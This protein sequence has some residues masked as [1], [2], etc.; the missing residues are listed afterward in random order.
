MAARA[1]LIATFCVLTLAIC[2]TGTTAQAQTVDDLSVII[3]GTQLPI[4]NDCASPCTIDISNANGTEKVYGCVKISGSTGGAPAQVLAINPAAGDETLKL[5]N[6]VIKAG[7]ANCYGE[8]SASAIFTSPPSTASGNVR[9][10]RFA[11]GTL[12]RGLGGATTDWSEG[13]GLV[14]TDPIYGWERWTVNCSTCGTFTLIQSE[15]WPEPQLPDPRV[16]SL[17]INFYLWKTTDKLTIAG[18]NQ[19]DIHT[20]PGGGGGSDHDRNVTHGS[21]KKNKKKQEQ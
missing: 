14:D 11:K 15:T 18:A 20:E 17:D 9:I 1:V 12:M 21:D 8:I 4:K 3:E 10:K 6:A 13:N 2:A 19:I 7:S 5:A 16:L